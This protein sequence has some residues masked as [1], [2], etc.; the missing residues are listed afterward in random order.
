MSPQD[1]TVGACET[2]RAG[3]R[4]G[5]G[6][7]RARSPDGA[8]VRAVAWIVAVVGVLL[9][10]GVAP[11]PA[12]A[13]PFANGG[14]EEPVIAGGF[15]TFPTWSS[16]GPWLVTSNSVDLVRDLWQPKEGA[17]S[18][19]LDGG[20]AGTLCQTFDAIVG[21][22]LV[23][24]WMSRNYFVSSAS[25]RVLVDGNPRGTFT[26][27]DKVAPQEMRWSYRSASFVASGATTTLCFESLT[28]GPY[29]PAIDAVGFAS[30]DADS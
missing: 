21:A 7:A 27:S 4:V 15:V 22:N 20:H 11:Q 24:F 28:P 8:R 29:G 9:G 30:V 13:A 18:I 14:F 25:L 26:H 19:D 2:M 5:R 1:P 17:Q 10:S 23:T 6:E 3:E 16:I 12:S